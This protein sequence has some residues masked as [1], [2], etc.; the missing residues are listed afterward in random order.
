MTAPVNATLTALK[1]HSA[2]EHACRGAM[3]GIRRSKKNPE[4]KWP[5]CRSIATHRKSWKD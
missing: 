3:D 4:R 1:P 5:F 2:L